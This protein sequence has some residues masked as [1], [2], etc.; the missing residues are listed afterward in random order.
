MPGVCGTW[1]ITGIT[2]NRS[3]GAA[4]RANGHVQPIV[5]CE[6]GMLHSAVVNSHALRMLILLSVLSLTVTVTNTTTISP[7]EPRDEINDN[8]NVG[9]SRIDSPLSETELTAALSAFNRASPCRASLRNTKPGAATHWGDR[10]SEPGSETCGGRVLTSV[11]IAGRRGRAD[12]TVARPAEGS[13]EHL[14]IGWAWVKPPPVS[15]LSPFTSAWM[16]WSAVLLLACIWR[17]FQDLRRRWWPGPTLGW[18]PGW[19]PFCGLRPLGRSVHGR[20]RCLAAGRS[21]IPAAR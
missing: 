20:C 5:S 21:W 14:S 1:G 8:L 4:P 18:W 2:T 7:I 15:R 19:Q 13:A 9:N 10:A 6:R 17:H 16:R 12:G 11:L 3:D